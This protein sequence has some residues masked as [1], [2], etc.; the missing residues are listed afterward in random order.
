MRKEIFCLV[1]LLLFFTTNA[2][3]QQ[4]P[5]AAQVTVIRAGKLIDVEAGRVQTN[6]MILVQIGRASCRER[7]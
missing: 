5:P 7:V 4:A 2:P 6:Q 1:F 3:A